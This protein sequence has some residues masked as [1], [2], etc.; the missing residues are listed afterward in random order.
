MS[1]K[2]VEAIKKIKLVISN[3]QN[4]LK[5]IFL[6]NLKSRY[7]IENVMRK[8]IIGYSKDKLR[9]RKFSR[10]V[11]NSYLSHDKDLSESSYLNNISNTYQSNSN[12]KLNNFNNSKGFPNKNFITSNFNTYNSTFYNNLN[13]SNKKN[14]VLH[15]EKNNEIKDTWANN[16]YF[17]NSNKKFDKKEK[18]FDENIK[19]DISERLYKRSKTSKKNDKNDTLNN[20]IPSWELK[21][22]KDY[23][24]CTF[25]PKINY[26]YPTCNNSNSK[27]LETINNSTDENKH[28]N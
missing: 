9:K 28:G 20:I 23:E 26:Y 18:N 12:T 17:L 27:N 8:Y 19:S 6:A 14:N 4:S 1:L 7:K 25:I 21:E 10:N 24:E 5:H 16:S 2:K 13:E 3:K 11:S 15:T 22:K